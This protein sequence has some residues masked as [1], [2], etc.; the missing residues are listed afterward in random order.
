MAKKPIKRLKHCD[1]C[2]Q[3]CRLINKDVDNLCLIV[4][5]QVFWSM[6]QPDVVEP[7]LKF[8]DYFNWKFGLQMVDICAKSI[9]IYRYYEFAEGLEKSYINKQVALRGFKYY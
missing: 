1:S 2:S 6:Y 4:G 7:A 9:S 5:I 3:I 8:C